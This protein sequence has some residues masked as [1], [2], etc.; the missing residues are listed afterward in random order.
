MS[1][2]ASAARH[3]LLLKC[4]HVYPVALS[5]PPRASQQLRLGCAAVFAVCIGLLRESMRPFEEDE[6]AE[7]HLLRIRATVRS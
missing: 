3:V 6:Q 2:K 1:I 4:R 5:V 7:G